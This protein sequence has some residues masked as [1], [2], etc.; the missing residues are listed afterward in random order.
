MACVEG[1]GWINP[2][3]EIN[4]FALLETLGGYTLADLD[5]EQAC[6]VN[7]WLTIIGERG[8]AEER[9]RKKAGG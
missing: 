7:R 9:A 5:G 6:T 3:A 1:R 2:P 8:K 4:E